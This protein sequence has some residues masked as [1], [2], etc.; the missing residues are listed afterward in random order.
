[1]L[2]RQRSGAN[3]VTVGFNHLQIYT[4]ATNSWQSSSQP[5]SSLAP[6]PVARGG[7]GTA[8][9]IAGEIYVIGGE[10]PL[11]SPNAPP[12]GV[13]TRVDIYNPTTNTWRAGPPLPEG[14]H[15]IYPVF[16]GSMIIIA[17]GG[18]RVGGSNS[19]RFFQLPVGG[20]IP[21]IPTQAPGSTTQGGPASSTV[22][23]PVGSSS[24]APSTVPTTPA[25]STT[26]T[27]TRATTRTTTRTTTRATTRTTVATSTTRT[28]VIT[29]TTKPVGSCIGRCGQ[30][31]KAQP[32]Q[33]DTHCLI[34]KDCCP[35]RATVCK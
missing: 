31:S 18:I 5:G 16:D 6:L 7:M 1:L 20:S 14:M 27:T 21:S 26:R 13:F 19:N 22:S 2:T 35:N 29:T 11:S 32:C 17:S 34:F 23:V 15:G 24:T 9:F 28:T 33:C 10:T 25:A 4:I 30:F 12:N 8:L 3:T